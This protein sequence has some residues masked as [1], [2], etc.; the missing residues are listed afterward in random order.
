MS[1]EITGKLH[2][3][4]PVQEISSSFKKREF[5]LEILNEKN[6]EWNDFVKFQ[7]TQDRC[8]AIDPIQTGQQ[9]KVSFNI[10]GRKWE[11]DGKTNYFSNLEAWKIESVDGQSSAAPEAFT[12]YQQTDIPPAEE[13]DDLPF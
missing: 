6:Q 13:G 4:E 11:K 10:K 8:S 9:V 7:L 2:L 12:Q 5:V 1:F 3:K